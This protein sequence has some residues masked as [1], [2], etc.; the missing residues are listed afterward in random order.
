M[1][2]NVIQFN[3]K[4][5]DGL[6]LISPQSGFAFET[7]FDIS[8]TEDWHLDGDKNLKFKFW[9][10][11]N[12]ESEPILLGKRIYD[13]SELNDQAFWGLLPELSIIET[14]IWGETGDPI[15]VVN[16]VSIIAAPPVLS[17]PEFDIFMENVN[18]IANVKTSVYVYL[19]DTIGFISD[20][21]QL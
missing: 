11:V 8:L 7:F 12:E 5:A 2:V 19:A 20:D 9:G 18:I 16:H 3:G 13:Y 15:I 17:P 6:V 4:P 21:I 14:E 10:R 1:P